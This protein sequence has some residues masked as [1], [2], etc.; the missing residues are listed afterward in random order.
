MDICNGQTCIHTYI[1]T[2]R[3][4]QAYKQSLSLQG[5]SSAAI[6][7]QG[8]LPSETPCL[9]AALETR[10]SRSA[11]A[12]TA[13]TTAKDPDRRH[14]RR[15]PA[16]TTGGTYARQ[17]GGLLYRV[18]SPLPPP[19]PPYLVIGM[20]HEYS[21]SLCE[22]VHAILR[23]DHFL[24]LAG[25]GFPLPPVLKFCLRKKYNGWINSCIQY[26]FP[27]VFLYIHLFLFLFL[28]FP[29][30]HSAIPPSDV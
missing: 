21:I 7:S 18:F 17:R 19:P 22:A 3:Q 5:A 14:S 1:K 6:P 2:D 9:E 16:P 20:L 23:W 13:R 4:R 12:G 11:S 10:W 25:G 24:L 29:L 26:K 30:S 15:P 28:F 27:F 8:S